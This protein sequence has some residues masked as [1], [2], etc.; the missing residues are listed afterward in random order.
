[1]IKVIK[2]WLSDGGVRLTVRDTDVKEP[3]RMWNFHTQK[4]EVVGTTIRNKIV[5]AQSFPRGTPK[6]D[7]ELAKKNLKLM[8]LT[9]KELT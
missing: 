6:A 3:M 8:F 5:Y 7:I 2:D 4:M 1:M 9:K